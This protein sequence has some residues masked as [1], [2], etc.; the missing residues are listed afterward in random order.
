MAIKKG[1]N[2]LT[3]IYLVKPKA[4]CSVN[5]KPK[6]KYSVINLDLL[7]DLPKDF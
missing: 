6:V 7:T 5:R 1:Y 2:L 3:E 4:T